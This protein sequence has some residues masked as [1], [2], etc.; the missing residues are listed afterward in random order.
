MSKQLAIRQF[1]AQAMPTLRKAPPLM[2]RGKRLKRSV[3]DFGQ[4]QYSCRFGIFRVL[5]CLGVVYSGHKPWLTWGWR[6]NTDLP[7]Y[8]G[9]GRD[10]C[11]T[12]ATCVTEVERT[13][14][15]LYEMLEPVAAKKPRTKRAA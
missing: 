14:G 4:V 7:I 10:H 5:I 1:V 3:Y 12:A 11:G 8:A 15:K 9:F 2:V 6:I 13:L